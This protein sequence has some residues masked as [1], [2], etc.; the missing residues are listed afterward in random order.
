[1]VPSPERRRPERRKVLPEGTGGV[2]GGVKDSHRKTWSEEKKNDFN[3]VFRG[4]WT[5][6]S[7]TWGETTCG[8]SYADSE[9]LSIHGDTNIDQSP[10]DVVFGLVPPFSSCLR[11]S[12]VFVSLICR[13]LLAT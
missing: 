9:A 1:M 3:Y 4:M 10:I 8:R 7:S 11:R 12:S 6:S 2:T 13:F 5:K